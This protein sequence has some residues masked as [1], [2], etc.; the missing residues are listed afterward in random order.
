MSRPTARNL[1]SLGLLLKVNFEFQ[2][3]SSFRIKPYPQDKLGFGRLGYFILW[4][5][6]KT[7]KVTK[8]SVSGDS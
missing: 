6:V 1:S 7:K 4:F 2:I 3:F 5:Y 8:I